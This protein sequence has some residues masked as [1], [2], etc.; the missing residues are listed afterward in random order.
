MNIQGIGEG[1]KHQAFAVAV[2]VVI[3]GFARTLTANAQTQGEPATAG[4]GPAS[5]RVIERRIAMLTSHLQLYSGQVSKI[6]AI[7][8]QEHELMM[9]RDNVGDLRPDRAGPGPRSARSAPLPEIREILDRTEREIEKV[10]S[11]R[12]LAEY[13]AL[14]EGRRLPNYLPQIR[15]RGFSV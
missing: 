6:R 11:T 10:L 4:Q 15:Q 13:R 2:A 9:L 1:M 12:Q 3:G 5:S 14:K 7:L 8:A